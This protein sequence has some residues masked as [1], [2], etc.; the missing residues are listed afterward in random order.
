MIMAK[1]F[2]TPD[3]LFNRNF[4][5]LSQEML[6]LLNKRTPSPIDNSLSVGFV[7]TSHLGKLASSVSLNFSATFRWWLYYSTD[8]MAL[9]QFQCSLPPQRSLC[10]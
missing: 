10:L 3:L 9:H 8:A 4:Q 7:R 1:R 2:G 6:S 5:S